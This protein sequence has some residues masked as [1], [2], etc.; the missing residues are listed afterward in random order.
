VAVYQSIIAQIGRELDRALP[1]PETQEQFVAS[2]SQETLPK[3]LILILDEFDALQQAPLYGVVA[4]FRDMY[5]IR[6]QEADRTSAEKTYLLHGVALIG[7]RSVLGLE[8]AS[9]SPFNIQRSIHIPNLTEDEVRTMFAWYEEES[10]QKFA[11]GVIDRV[12]YE[13]RG[14]PGLTCWLG[15]LL[16]EK[17]NRHETEITMDDF[18]LAYSFA[19]NVLPNN[20]I[21]NIVSKAK[22]EQYKPLVLDLFQTTKKINFRY[23]DPTVNFLYMNGVVDHETVL[24]DGSHKH[25]LKFPNPF[26]QKRLFNYFAHELYMNLTHLHDP[27]LDL[28]NVV[29]STHLDIPAVLGLYEEYLQKNRGWLFNGVP[30]RKGDERIYE[31]VYHF[32]FYMYLTQ[33]M[34]DYDGTVLPE[35]PTGNG[36]IDLLIR[37]SGRLYGLEV[38]SYANRAEYDKALVQAAKYANR[39]NTQEIWLVLFIE[40]IDDDTRQQLE[41]PYVDQTYGV[42]VQPVFVT[43]GSMR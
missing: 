15:E 31:A 9:G 32:N 33:F 23:G 40:M 11:P 13:M 20:N 19:V 38:K 36:Q 8:S 14:Q 26:I 17:Y 7:V 21:V 10:G 30:R 4:A 5:N 24:G 27:L 1:V 41:K 43:I 12:Y 39:L 22:Q 6:H 35:F 34:Y 42:T 18:E 29:T 28:S 3:P 37:H 25:Y 16:T 2:F